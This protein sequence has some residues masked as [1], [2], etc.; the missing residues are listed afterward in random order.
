MWGI[1]KEKVVKV[2][3]ELTR[4]KIDLKMENQMSLNQQE[5]WMQVLIAK[6]KDEKKITQERVRED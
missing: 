5:T 4:Q 6:A 3:S 2:D 1:K